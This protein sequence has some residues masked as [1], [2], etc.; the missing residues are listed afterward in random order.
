[1]PQ[2]KTNKATAPVVGRATGI[3]PAHGIVNMLR[4]KA[5]LRG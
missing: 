4:R 3:L 2:A 5:N 1:M